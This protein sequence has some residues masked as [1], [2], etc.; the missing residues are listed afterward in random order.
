MK[1]NFLSI[2]NECVVGKLHM[3]SLEMVDEI[4]CMSHVTSIAHYHFI[5]FSKS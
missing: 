2:E 3:E 1:H 4:H 5:M